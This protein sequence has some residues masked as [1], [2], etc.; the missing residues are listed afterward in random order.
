MD[1]L[2]N[3]YRRRIAN[4]ALARLKRKTGGNLLIIKLPDNKIETVEV[5]EH[6]MNQ[7]LLRF[8]GLTRGGLNRYEGDATIKTAYQ[9]AIG[10]NKHTEYLTDSGKLIIDELLN[11]V[12]DYVKQKHVSR[13]IN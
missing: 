13:G 9:N 7:L 5:K 6:F 2:I 8:E 11:E 3:T 10:I 1:N 4:A 12:V